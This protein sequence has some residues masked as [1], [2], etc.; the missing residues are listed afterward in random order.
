MAVQRIQPATLTGMIRYA[1]TDGDST[2]AELL[3]RA[4]RWAEDGVEYVQLREKQR[5]A[6]EL[7]ELAK[8]LMAIFSAHGSRT[9][10]LVNGRADVALAAEADGVHLTAHPDELTPGQVRSVFA[11]AGRDK[12]L[13]SLSCH[14]VAEAR[15]ARDEGANL[16]LFGPVFE[17]RIG[18][19]VV[20][21]GLGLQTLEQACGAAGDLPVLALG[22]VTAE[23]AGTCY[24]VGAVGIAG[25]RLFK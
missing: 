16:I 14:S 19:A 7:V 10:L 17:K 24:E 5:P 13:V 20:V 23:S 2:T 8:A 22:G 3:D 12:P 21:A 6:G 4:Q 1:I 9:K 25:I 11:L 18:G 15:R